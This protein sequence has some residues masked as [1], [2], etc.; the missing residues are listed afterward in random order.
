LEPEPDNEDVDPEFMETMGIMTGL[1]RDGA[2]GAAAV[3][4]ANRM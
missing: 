4:K 3:E 2:M 1:K